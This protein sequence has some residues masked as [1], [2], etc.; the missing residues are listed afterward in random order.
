MDPL[1]YTATVLIMFFLLLTILVVQIDLHYKLKAIL[2][3]D[4]EGWED[5]SKILDYREWYIEDIRAYLQELEELRGETT[6]V[7]R[8][9]VAKTRSN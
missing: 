6:W 8:L 2:Q 5:A 1:I 4:E 9:K 7:K 3:E